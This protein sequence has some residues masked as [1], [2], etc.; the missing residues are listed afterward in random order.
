M[1]L[2][3]VDAEI[4][5]ANGEIARWKETLK[6]PEEEDTPKETVR[7][8]RGENI[9]LISEWYHT[10]PN[11]GFTIPELANETG[12]PNGSVHNVVTKDESGYWKDEEGKWWRGEQSPERSLEHP[13]NGDLSSE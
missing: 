2:A 9:R 13:F 8:R 11:M 7:R 12:L 10:H 5:E 3:E 4:A 1:L 6:D